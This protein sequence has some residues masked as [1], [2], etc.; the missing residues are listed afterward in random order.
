MSLWG[1][2]ERLGRRMGAD[3]ERLAREG[4]EALAGYVTAHPQPLFELLRKVKP[5]LLVHGLA[6]VTRYDDVVAVLRNDEAF[7]VA[8]YRT[9]MESLLG[10]FLL[11]LESS[12]AYERQVSI[13]RLAAPRSDVPG[14]AAFVA[15]AAEALVAAGHGRIEVP[16]LTRR[17]PARLARRWL[18][19][20]AADD[21][22]LIAATLALFEDI[23]VNLDNDAGIHEAAVAAEA[24]LRPQVEAEIARRKAAGG[25]EDDVLG[26][27]LAMQ[28]NP[29]TEL[30]DAQVV[31]NLIGLAVGFVPP[32]ATVVTLALDA[33]LDRPAALAGAQA[34]ARADDDEG[35]RAHMWEAMRL[36]PQGPGLVRRAVA[37]VV[38][39]EG[40]RHATPIKAGTITFAA[41]QSAMLDESVVEDPEA[42][43]VGRP[44][45]HYLHFGTGLHTCFGRHLNAMQIPLIAK[46]LLR[47]EN[48]ARAPGDAGRL[49]KHGP[50]PRSLAVTF[51][52]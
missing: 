23:F 46:P 42:F 8:P 34:A 52:A 47:R 50:F 14:L 5:V 31:A 1:E 49:V 6:I 15:G 30:P 10:D 24:V 25:G 38:I 26:R 2:L 48:L 33:L 16:E 7:G 11:G 35:V 44:A 21:D 39:G 36:A 22:A 37:D 29:V 51:Q 43:R 20:L 3:A 19:P 27:L 32:V 13:L 45:H 9:K 40:T 28:A 12:P 4:E 18:G 17:V 41:T